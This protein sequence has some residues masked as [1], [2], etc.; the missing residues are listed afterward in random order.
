MWRADCCLQPLKR[1]LRSQPGDQVRDFHSQRI[2]NNFERLNRD[3]RFATFDLTHVGAIEAR[4]IS[5]RIL[6]ESFSCTDSA[7]IHPDVFLNILHLIEVW[8]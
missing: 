1:V 3:I 6:R 7:N 8:V 2:G 4:T 5:K